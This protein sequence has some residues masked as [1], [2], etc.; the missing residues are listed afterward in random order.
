MERKDCAGFTVASAGCAAVH[1]V[2][3]RTTTVHK[4]QTALKNKTYY[5]IVWSWA[6]RHNTT[7]LSVS[8]RDVG[9]RILE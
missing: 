7:C 9:R 8:F 5:T 4:A 6:K 3:I 2:L 1:C